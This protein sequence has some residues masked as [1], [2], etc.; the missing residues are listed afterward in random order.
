M[1]LPRTR[2][3][4][5]QVERLLHEHAKRAQFR[6]T[7]PSVAYGYMREQAGSSGSGSSLRF[8]F[9]DSVR[10]EIQGKLKREMTFSTLGAPTSAGMPN[11]MSGSHIADEDLP[12][13]KRRRNYDA[14]G[15][16]TESSVVLPQGRNILDLQTCRPELSTR[17]WVS[18]GSAGN[19]PSLKPPS[20]TVKNST[21]NSQP[22]G[23]DANATGNCESSSS[24][25]EILMTEENLRA[26]LEKTEG[27]S[28]RL[29]DVMRRTKLALQIRHQQH[30]MVRVVCINL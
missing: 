15:S 1:T 7:V 22:A 6:K 4:R 5:L 14:D 26:E 12:Q 11:K 9:Q 29:T 24:N 25:R 8:S 21:L 16:P 17:V 27:D 10:H 13:S 23:I 28:D 2:R 30:A 3:D 20:S 18:L 19:Q